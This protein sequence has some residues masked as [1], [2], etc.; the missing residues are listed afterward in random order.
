MFE[1]AAPWVFGIVLI[2]IALALAIFYPRQG[3]AARWRAWRRSV[4]RQQIEDALKYTFNIQ[5]ENHSPSVDALAGALRLSQRSVLR[6]VAQMQ[7]Q[8]LV[9]Q[10]RNRVY[11]TPEG[12]RWAL[13]VVRAHRLWERYLA[14]E[15]RVPLDQIH[16]MAH[17]LEH[18]ST[19]EQIDDLDAALGHPS[20][21]PHGDPI[22]NAAGVLRQSSDEE[23]QAVALT[24]WEVGKRGQ[25]V[26]L[27][28]EPPVAYAQ[29]VAE[30]LNVGQWVDLLERTNERLTLTDGRQE[31][32]IAPAIAANVYLRKLEEAEG[33][34]ENL[35][36]LSSL[37]A[38]AAA[39]IVRLDERC[40]GFSRRRFL[41]LGL[42]PGT[43][44]FPELENPFGEPR[45]YR[46]RGTLIALRND[47]AEMI[48]VEP[49]DVS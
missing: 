11:L 34:Q 32:R 28:D 35:V 26:H 23:G 3:L 6:L 2:L 9:E 39:K 8:N 47:Q 22:P 31:M 21:D 33:V 44:I 16:E 1:I 41:D 27:E 14:D 24:D 13:Q 42:T 46:V 17:K 48:L 12:Q 4:E 36:S 30:G 38:R 20:R 18:K 43:Q 49:E 7:S 40:Q 15:A 37:P 10:R 5:Q 25:I 45:G 19:L 29:L